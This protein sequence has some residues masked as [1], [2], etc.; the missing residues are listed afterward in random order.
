MIR[1]ESL[2]VLISTVFFLVASLFDNDAGLL[3]SPKNVDFGEV[4]AGESVTFNIELSNQGNWP[5]RIHGVKTSCDCTT[6]SERRFDIEPGK[7]QS[8]TIAV[9][10]PHASRSFEGELIIYLNEPIRSEKIKYF[11]VTK[12]QCNS[13]ML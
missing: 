8:I 12:Q 4:T 9:E 7:T 10:T 6:I 1:T 5:V 2:I 3:I 13:A 11:G